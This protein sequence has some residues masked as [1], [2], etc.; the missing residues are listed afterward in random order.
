M[1]FVAD[2]IR[3]VISSKCHFRA[4]Q[5]FLDQKDLQ[6]GEECLGNLVPQGCQAEMVVLERED[7]KG[8]EGNLDLP[9]AGACQVPP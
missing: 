2:L 1:S 4:Y 6:A 7:S 9:E 3:Q 8:R 5:G